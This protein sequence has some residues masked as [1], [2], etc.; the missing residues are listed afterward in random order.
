[1]KKILYAGL[2]T[3]ASG[4]G[5]AARKYLSTLDKYL[6]HSK[7][8][9]KAAW[10][11]Y[12]KQNYASKEENEL[13]SKY[14]IDDEKLNAFIEDKDYIILLHL[15]P[16]FY[17]HASIAPLYNNA[18]KR[19]NLSY[20]ESDRLPAEWREIFSSGVYDQLILACNWNKK[21]YD[22][23]SMS[24]SVVIPVPKY[25][26]NIKKNINSIFTIFS[27]SQWQYRKGFDILIKAFYQEFFNQED[28]KLFIKTYR[29][30]AQAGSDEVEQRN[31]IVSEAVSYKNSVGHY[32]QSPKCKLEIL[33]GIVSE[34]ELLECYKRADVFCL[35]TRGE[36]FG[37][38]MADAAL[39]GIPCIAPDT[40][41]HADLLDK[42][43]SFMVKTSY[44][45]VENMSFPFYS[46]VDM[47]FIETDI[48]DLRRHLRSAYNMWK[49][50]PLKLIEM[51]ERN[52]L[53]TQKYLNDK[54]IFDKLVKYFE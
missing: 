14:L 26:Q 8:D 36:G 2:F 43:S 19:I 30:E 3:D 11:S 46:S 35:A 12:E 10:I 44:K 6:D 45:P 24:P 16:S 39:Y 32:N 38:T 29:A 22:K 20:W 53:F 40:G 27:M 13:L 23:D 52:K 34:E 21:T 15:I 48:Y 50:S 42:Q 7:Y 28:V 31:L 17:R 47:N 5:N 4:Y 1:M 49:E 33:T 51:G 18:K 41:G 54:S 9:L 25:N 37:L